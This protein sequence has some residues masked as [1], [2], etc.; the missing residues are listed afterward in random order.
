MTKI[1]HMQMTLRVISV[2][3][4]LSLNVAM[5]SLAQTLK[6]DFGP[7]KM[8]TGFMQVIATTKYSATTGFGFE[9]TAGI[10]CVDRTTTDAL[11][12]DYCTGP[13]DFQFSVK[14]PQG[15]YQVTFILGDAT[16]SSETT[17]KVENRRLLFDR[18]MT[19]AGQ[20]VSKTITVNR[21]E[22]KSEDGSVTMTLKDRE[23]TYFT[24]DDKLTFR[25]TGA[26]PAICSIELTKV[27]DAITL[28][29][30]G[31]STVVDQLDELEEGWCSWG[32]TIT[33]FF[34]PGVSIANYAESGLTSGGF[35]S[36]KRLTKLLADAKPGDYV[37]VEFGHN[38]QKNVADVAAYSEHLK[39]FRDQILAKQA[40]PIFVAPT[41]REGDTDPKVS[42]AGLAEEMRQTAKTLNVTLIDL[43]AMVITLTKALG[44]DKKS[45]YMDGTHFTN[46]GGFELGRCMAKGIGELKNNLAPFLVNDIPVFD[47]AKPDPL[48]YLLTPGVVSTLEKPK[49]KPW[50]RVSRYKLHR[51]NGVRIPLK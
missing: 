22:P 35:L 7:G 38:D 17:I 37:F 26:K 34:K 39:A 16:E 15:N 4:I 27:N 19:T 6:Y 40:I 32:Q 28:F 18:V 10:V 29:L 33:R 5:N 1:K 51:I 47:P 50:S 31:N 23:L 21:R 11:R 30:C 36:M 20:T 48:N 45:L 3:S 25:F 41:A 12:S 9:N 24:W 42:I 46:Y 44:T 8:A 2:G 49:V 43:N 13:K 14:V